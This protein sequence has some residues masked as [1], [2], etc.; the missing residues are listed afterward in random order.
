MSLEACA[1]I[2]LGDF[3]VNKQHECVAPHIPASAS[4]AAQNTWARNQACYC[5]L[6]TAVL[7]LLLWKRNG[8]MTENEDLEPLPAVTPQPGSFKLAYLRTG[9]C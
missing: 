6:W 1:C 7:L 9:L 8:S 3:H 2:V 4:E 5:M